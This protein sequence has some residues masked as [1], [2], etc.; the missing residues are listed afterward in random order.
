[1]PLETGCYRWQEL[2]GERTID[3][4]ETPMIHIVEADLENDR[5]AEAIVPLL[6]AYACDLMGGGE[7]LS[8][9]CK[10]N[11]VAELR[12]LPHAVVLLAFVDDVPAGLSICF[13]GFSTF[14]CKP[15]LN[16]HD[17]AVCERFRG[18]GIGKQ[19]M[20]RIEEIAV[21]KGCCKLTLE[22][23]SGNDVAL[24]L[25][26]RQGFLQYQL[27]PNAGGAMFL[28]KKLVV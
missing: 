12:R 26:R 9:Y 8:D 28:Q 5:H 27:D 23:L 19:L 17:L 22:V 14:A 6:N 20:Q 16:I 13:L 1:M 7:D 10:R 3:R 21:R 15:L 24:N 18:L 4:K 25:Y 2:R 11:L